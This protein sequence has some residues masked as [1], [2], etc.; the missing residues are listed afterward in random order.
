MTDHL[1]TPAKSPKRGIK[2]QTQSASLPSV[3]QTEPASATS[4]QRKLMKRSSKLTPKDI[5]VRLIF[6]IGVIVAITF[7]VVCLGLLWTFST[8][9][10]PLKEQAPN[11]QAIISLLSTI[12]TFIAGSLGGI[13]ASNGF[14]AEPKKTEEG[15]S[16]ENRS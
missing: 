12:V 3:R 10:Q 13:L 6:T 2:R 14:K 15:I 4:F 9:T 7:S 16:D 1:D 5:H 11:D 8:V